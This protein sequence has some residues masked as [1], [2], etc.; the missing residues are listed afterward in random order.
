MEALA[1]S[2]IYR[3]IAGH[4]VGGAPSV[5]SQ[6]HMGIEQAHRRR[7][8]EGLLSGRVSSGYR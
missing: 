4:C 5:R 7:E 1:P 3:I 8:N 2:A 6:A